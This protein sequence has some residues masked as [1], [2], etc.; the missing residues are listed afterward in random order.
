MPRAGGAPALLVV[1]V[2]TRAAAASAARAGFRVVSIDGYADADQHPDVRALSLPRDF[3]RPF[4]PS[5]VVGAARGLDVDAVVYLSNFENHPRAVTRL[6]EGRALWGNS[7][8]T[9]RGVR[10]PARLAAALRRRGL[11]ALKT[12]RRAPGGGPHAWL[13][14]PR[15]SGG[16]QGTKRWRAGEPVP[17][18]WHL[19]RFV[20]GVPG[21]VVFVAANGLA[22]PIGISRQL[23]GDAA[24]GASGFRYCGSLLVSTTALQRLGE[25]GL[26]DRACAL[27]D[28]VAADF[29]LTGVGG[30]DFVAAGGVPWPV[31]VNPRWTASMELVER[32]SGLSV[33]AAHVDACV[34]G[35]L[36]RVRPWAAGDLVHGK[37]IVFAR[38]DVTMGDTR[39]WLDDGTVADVPHAGER[40]PAG[41]PVCTVFASGRDE[42]ACYDALVARAARVYAEIDASR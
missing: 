23:V 29:R 26:G 11:D 42:Q 22:V 27:V 35:V 4:T 34:R 40:I 12:T 15:A 24:F 32:A 41:S 38:V 17:R 31:E 10:D 33:F 39:P 20:D 9:L 30:I 13:L 7:A 8:E 14:K 37:A 1:G 6:A 28:A 2:S 18:G 36:P 5:A 16:G 21:S 25:R 19:Q 3:H